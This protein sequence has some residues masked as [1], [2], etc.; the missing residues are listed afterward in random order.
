MAGFRVSIG[1][2]IRLWSGSGQFPDDREC[3]AQ[4]EGRIQVRVSR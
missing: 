1:V 2:S 3:K 4:R